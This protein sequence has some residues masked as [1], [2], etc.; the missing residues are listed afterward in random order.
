VIHIVSFPDME[1][2]VIL[3]GCVPIVGPAAWLTIR[4]R[5]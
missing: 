2:L 4:L 3:L 5:R 1:T